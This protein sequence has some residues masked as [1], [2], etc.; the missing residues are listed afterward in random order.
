MKQKFDCFYLPQHTSGSQE[1]GVPR[2]AVLGLAGDAHQGD[3]AHAAAAGQPG[4]RAHILL[5]DVHVTST[6][7]T[8]KRTRDVNVN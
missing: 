6:S 8:P 4:E 3:A 2:G 7:T 5:L 1:D